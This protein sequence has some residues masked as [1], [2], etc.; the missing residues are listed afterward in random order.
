MMILFV[1]V[2]S[3]SFDELI[4]VLD[5]ESFYDECNKT[6]FS[7]I[8]FQIGKGDYIPCKHTY[9]KGIV[10]WFRYRTSIH[11]YIASASLVISAGGAGTMS[12]TLK[13][14][15]PLIV[16]INNSLLHN[17]Q[18]ELASKFQSLS[19]LLTAS[20]PCEVR[21]LLRT[22]LVYDFKP[23]PES[24]PELLCD[25]LISKYFEKNKTT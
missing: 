3:T 10:E 2:G 11:E 4:S 15:K 25:F 12:E 7:R 22:A 1:T 16:V 9:F 8:V 6:G 20:N 24:H 19:C 21:S 17:H 13:L 14:R 23:L 5:T 18:V